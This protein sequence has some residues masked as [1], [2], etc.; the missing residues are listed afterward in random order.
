MAV[1]IEQIM[2][3]IETR[4]ATISGLRVAEYAPDQI[5][6]PQAIVGV[7]PVP[8][9]RRTFGAEGYLNIEPTVTVL[10]SAALDRTGQMKLAS[11]TDKTGGQ[12][13]YAAIEA[14]KTLGIT[15]VECIVKSFEP[16]G[17]RDVGAL[18]YYGGVFRLACIAT[19]T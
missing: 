9:Y 16:L 19:G 1:T 2:L 10:V 15:G 13:I 8:D 4:L 6:P 14:D 12:S 7:P 18:G 5:N 17:L 3:G 11:Y